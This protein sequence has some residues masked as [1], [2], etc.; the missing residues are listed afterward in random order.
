MRQ[1]G[2]AAILIVLVIGCARDTFNPVAPDSYSP[3]S[4]LTQ[5]ASTHNPPYRFL[6][7][8]YNFYFNETHDQVD[9][10]PKRSQNFHLNATK[11]LEEY[12]KNCLQI[13]SIQNNHDGTIDLTVRITHPFNGYPQYTGFDVKGIIIFNGSF[14]CENR[15]TKNPLPKPF[16]RISWREMGDPEV[17]NPDG[18]TPRWSPNYDCGSD[19]PIFN[20]W[21]G[22][23]A[24][25]T[26]NADLNA[27]LNFYSEERRHIFHHYASVTRTYHI[28]LP[29]GPVIAGYA[30]EACWE[31]PLVTPVTNPLS[32]FPVTANQPE[33]YC[34][35]YV[36]NNG[37]VI[38]DCDEYSPPGPYD[39]DCDKAYVEHRQWGGFT[40]DRWSIF[41]PDWDS[42]GGG[43]Y[44][45]KP[46]EPEKF[47]CCSVSACHYGN[48][49]FRNVLYCFK[50]LDGKCSDW[51]YSVF[52]YTVD[53]PELD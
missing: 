23:F 37:E 31:P 43:F 52:D 32:D 50:F 30:I 48:G 29:P 46:P 27:F 13:Q 25:G 2:L 6:W 33:P 26:P 53:D 1:I 5:S 9:V 17:L 49:T 36:V 7:G 19:L 51:T 45:C 21:P 11:F 35:R 34:F 8:N 40:S 44:S 47:Y 14:E 38:T 15:S 28:C 18:Y 39:Y 3:G 12:C 22:R 10:V 20:Y 24:S 41:W 42:F 4:S 16:F